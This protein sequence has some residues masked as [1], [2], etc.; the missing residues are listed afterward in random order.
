MSIH[1]MSRR[2]PI[3]GA[4]TAARSPGHAGFA[5]TVV[6]RARAVPDGGRLVDVD[7]SGCAAPRREVPP[8]SC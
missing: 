7:G 1:S 2:V 4:N 3:A 6:E 5:V 8:C